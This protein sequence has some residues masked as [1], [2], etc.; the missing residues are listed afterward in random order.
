MTECYICG[1]YPT[2]K[3]KTCSTE[4]CH[5]HHVLLHG[6]KCTIGKKEKTSRLSESIESYSKDIETYS[7]PN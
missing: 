7:S 3:C 2:I 1:I 4:S 6:I 5:G